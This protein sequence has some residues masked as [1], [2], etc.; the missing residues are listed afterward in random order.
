MIGTIRGVSVG[1]MREIN[2]G[3]RSGQLT[4]TFAA[5]AVVT[6]M[7]LPMLSPPPS[8]GAIPSSFRRHVETF[9]VWYGPPNWIAASGKND[10]QISSPTGTLWNNY[11]AG[12]AVCPRTAGQWFQFVSSNFRQTARQ[13][14]GL[15]SKPLAAARY[16]RRGRI[17]QRGQGYFRQRLQWAG[18]SGGRQIRGELI[19]DIFVV[20]ALSGICGQRFQSRGAPAR[21]NGRSIRL[22]RTVQ[23]TITQQN[24]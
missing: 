2:R 15:Y 7:L 19:M 1:S 23:S 24:L 9:W 3:S 17:R 22:L 6:G 11:G 10:I 13:G 12:G 20:D 16:S 4:I 5:I 14:Q 18:R 21:R 8:D